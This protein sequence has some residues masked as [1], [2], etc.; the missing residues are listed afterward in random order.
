MTKERK[1]F[2][3]GA[4]RDEIKADFSAISHIGLR[5]LAETHYE[6]DEKYG[7]GNWRKGIPVHNLLSH[8][9]GHIFKFI[10]GDRSE[11]HL[12]HAAW[13]IFAAMHFEETM[14]A[15]MYGLPSEGKAQEI[16]DSIK[17]DVDHRPVVLLQRQ[18]GYPNSIATAPYR[19]HDGDA[20]YDLAASHDVTITAGSTFD[21]L[22]GWNIKVPAGYWGCIKPRSSTLPKKGVVVLEGVIDETY[23]G[24]LSV[25]V[26]NPGLWPVIIKTGDRL[27]QLILMKRHDV[28]FQFVKHLPETE[29]GAQG[30]GSTGG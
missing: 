19:K 11:D 18:E 17:E 22:T 16:I 6:G 15:M 20:G 13:G 3:T 23:T 12:G 29:R 25:I 26:F 10:W 5:R 9:V 30:F 21:V 7:R 27:A 8:A 24:Q 4:H 28:R 2:E 1:V 14:P